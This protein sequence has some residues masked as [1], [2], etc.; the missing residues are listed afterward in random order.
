MAGVR[1]QLT[2]AGG[3]IA[4]VGA[5]F[6]AGYWIYAMQANKSV[7]A[8]PMVLAG[9]V[10]FVG[11]CFMALGLLV[12]SDSGPPTQIQRGGKDSRNYQAGRDISIRDERPNE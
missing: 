9:V 4:G 5:T 6:A 2:G 10:L 11:I 3:S 8:W 1:A 12:G 7:W